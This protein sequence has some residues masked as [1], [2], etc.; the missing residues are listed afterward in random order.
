MTKQGLDS[1]V[2]EAPLPLRLVPLPVTVRLV[3]NLV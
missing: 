3:D 2:L 1:P